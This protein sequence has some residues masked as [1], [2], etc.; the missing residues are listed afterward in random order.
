MSPKKIK[1][2]KILAYVLLV[3]SI[4]LIPTKTVFGLLF[5]TVA[6]FT[7]RQAKLAESNSEQ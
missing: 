1:Q 6:L 3:C 5:L 2:Q 7:L 4:I